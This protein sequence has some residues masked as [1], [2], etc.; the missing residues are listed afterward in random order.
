MRNV[1]ESS[2]QR[3]TESRGP[4]NLDCRFGF[5]MSAVEGE[6]GRRRSITPN[7]RMTSVARGGFCFCPPQTYLS[8]A[9]NKQTKRGF[10]GSF[11]VSMSALGQAL[12]TGTK[13]SRPS[14][15]RSRRALRLSDRK[16]DYNLL[17]CEFT[18]SPLLPAGSAN[19]ASKILLSVRQLTFYRL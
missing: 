17:T 11:C 1:G 15:K 4:R 10:A 14:P 2:L 3:Q 6:S 5:S 13:S 9:V 16:P 7:P 18:H 12:R 8:A 19:G